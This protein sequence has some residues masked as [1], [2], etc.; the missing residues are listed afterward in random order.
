MR[1]LASALIGLAWL[2][3][4]CGSADAQTLLQRLEQRLNQLNQP[5]ASGAG[6]AE[7]PAAKTP[8]QGAPAGDAQG[9]E[10][11]SRPPQR[12]YLGL[13]ADDAEEAGRG[14]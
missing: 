10:A 7:A 5:A 8:Q 13:I 4:N 1:T 9:Q 6:E 14:V 2:L 11:E 3:S 12:G